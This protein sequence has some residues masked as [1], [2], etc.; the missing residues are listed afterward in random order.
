MPPKKAPDGFKFCPG[1][2]LVL[3]LDAFYKNKGAKRAAPVQGRCKE[4]QK[5]AYKTWLTKPESKE[6]MRTLRRNW[7]EKNAEHD[8]RYK[9]GQALKRYGLT[10]ESYAALL[11]SQD[12]RCGS[13]GRFPEGNQNLH[14]DHDHDTNVV[15]GLLCGNCNVALGLLHDCAEGVE[16][17]LSYIRTFEYRQM[18]FE[19]EL[20]AVG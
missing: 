1:C 9:R 16:L 6:R 14:V 12:G 8:R 20:D 15:R 3:P 4:C 18:G 2:E 11:E 13:C 5:A 10:I 17:L 19:E 7:R